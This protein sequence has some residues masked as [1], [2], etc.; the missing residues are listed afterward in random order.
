MELVLGSVLELPPG[1]TNQTES[2]EMMF[3]EE[4]GLLIMVRSLEGEFVVMGF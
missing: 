1:V 2:R 4:F 3:L